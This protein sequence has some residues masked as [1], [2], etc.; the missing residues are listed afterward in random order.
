VGATTVGGTV[1]IGD[2]TLTFTDVKGAHLQ[3]PKYGCQVIVHVKMEGD[4]GCS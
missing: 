4:L 1:A 2:E 3:Q